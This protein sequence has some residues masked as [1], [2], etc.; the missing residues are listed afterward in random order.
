MNEIG[1]GDSVKLFGGGMVGLQFSSIMESL[2]S[3]LNGIVNYNTY[4]PEK[5]MDFPGVKDFL[6]RYS[7]RAAQEKVDLLGLLP[8][9]LQLCHRADARAGDHRDQEPRSQGVGG[10]PAQQ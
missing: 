8:A 5:T 7:Q 6:A 1:V 10:L 9:A 4:V 2:G 3:K